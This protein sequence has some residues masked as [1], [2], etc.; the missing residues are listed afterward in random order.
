MEQIKKIR[1]LVQATSLLVTT[2][3]TISKSFLTR[4]IIL[5]YYYTLY[6]SIYLKK[7]AIVARLVHEIFRQDYAVHKRDFVGFCKL[8]CG[9]V[10]VHVG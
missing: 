6:I 10:E 4:D 5:I 2:K 9:A 3:Y 7:I 1:A 8:Q